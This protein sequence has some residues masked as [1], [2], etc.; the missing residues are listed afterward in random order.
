MSAGEYAVTLSLIFLIAGVVALPK[1]LKALYLFV[2]HGPIESSVREVGEAVVR[3]LF[4]TGY[5]KT[6][7]AR[8]SIRSERDKIGVV[9]C[10]L[11][12]ATTYEKSLFLDSLEEILGPIVNPRY[13]L[14][15]KSL[16]WKMT[17]KDYHVV[18]DIIGKKKESAEYFSKMWSKYVGPSK[19]IY[20][21]TAGG[22]RMLLRARGRAMSSAFQKRSE[23]VKTWK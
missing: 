23:R 22:R 8:L 16:F 3:T 4:Y 19:L 5:I 7:V 14:V 10:S 18:P 12:G 9:R 21:R 11:G 2:K 17:R 13:I 20:T 1:C 15:R 6:P